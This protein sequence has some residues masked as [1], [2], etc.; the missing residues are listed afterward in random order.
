MQ[1]DA[2][3]PVGLELGERGTLYLIWPFERP[4]SPLE[5]QKHYSRRF[6]VSGKSKEVKTIAT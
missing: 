6:L 2:S 3:C 5:P 4:V 1:N